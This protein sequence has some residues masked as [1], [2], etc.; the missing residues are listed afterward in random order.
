VHRKSFFSLL[1]IDPLRRLMREERPDIVHARSRV[2]AWL[3]W[4]ALKGLPSNERPRF[5]TTVH[6]FYSVNAY[7]A[8]MTRGERVIAV[9]ESIREYILKNYRKTPPEVIRVIQRG[10]AEEEFPRGYKASPEWLAQ[11]TKAQPQL[12][13][14]RIL[15]LPARLTRWKGQEDFLA[16]VA[17]LKA[18]GE[19]VHGLMAG[20][21][22]KNKDRFVAELRELAVKLGVADDVTFLGHRNDLREVMAVSDVVL[23][24]SRDPEAFGRVTLEAA[25]LGRPVVGYAHGGVKE[26]LSALFPA[27]LVALGDQKGLVDV[28]RRL[29]QSP[30]IPREICPPFTRETMCRATLDTYKELLDTSNLPGLRD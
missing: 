25:A 11:W 9:S 28:I 22:R 14:K 29:L 3:A 20:E 2:P 24:L 15:L 12:L 19:T 10:V 13:N 7:S 27:G 18:A 8:I 1:K 16:L 23:S 21:A 17:S 4:F 5:V 26:Q 6:G 30:E